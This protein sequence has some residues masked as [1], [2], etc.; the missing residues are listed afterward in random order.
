MIVER[1]EEIEAF[2]AREYWT[3]EAQLQACRR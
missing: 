3:I 1:E 2:V